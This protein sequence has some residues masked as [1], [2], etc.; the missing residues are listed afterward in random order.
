MILH[1]SKAKAE[2]EPL[3]DPF[4]GH[5]NQEIFNLVPTKKARCLQYLMYR[6]PT[7]QCPSFATYLICQIEESEIALPRHHWIY[8]CLDNLSESPVAPG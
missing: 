7:T 6:A 3:A 8:H 2:R 5:Q 4:A 1:S